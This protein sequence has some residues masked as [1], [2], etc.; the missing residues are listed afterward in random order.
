MAFVPVGAGLAHKT[1][2]RLPRPAPVSFMILTRR[3]VTAA[4][5]AAAAA[6]VCAC[7]CA[8]VH[9][10]VSFCRCV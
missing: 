10:C 5:A 3:I 4:A 8:H 1:A 9:V 7:G 6:A 2:A